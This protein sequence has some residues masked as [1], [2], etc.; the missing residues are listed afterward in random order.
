[1]ELFQMITK[2]GLSPNA[3]YLLASMYNSIKPTDINI[4]QELRELKKGGWIIQD[5]HGKY[6]LLNKSYTFVKKV[7]I[8]CLFAYNKIHMLPVHVALEFAATPLSRQT[9][10][11]I[12]TNN[13]LKS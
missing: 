2:E 11:I 13:L 9:F 6:F 4:H 12:L 1:M 5:E 7:E 10:I 8:A 3:Y